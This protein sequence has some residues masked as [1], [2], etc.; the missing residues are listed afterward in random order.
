MLCFSI[1]AARQRIP[2]IDSSYNKGG[3]NADSLRLRNS[4]PVRVTLKGTRMTFLKSHA[5]LTPPLPARARRL[6][7]VLAVCLVIAVSGSSQEPA[8]AN[9]AQTPDPAPAQIP[10]AAPD[11]T[12]AQT[13]DPTPAQPPVQADPGAQPAQPDAAQPAPN[14]AVPPAAAQDTPAQPAAQS[15]DTP[16]A[17]DQA[18]ATPGQK[19]AGEATGEITEDELKNMLVGKPL[20][21]RNGY[22]FDSLSYNEL[23]MLIGKSPHASYTLSAVQ[24]EKVHLTK[25]KLELEGARYGLHFLGSLASEDPTAGIDRV[26]ITPKKKKLRISI[27]REIVIKPKKAKPE[28]PIKGKSETKPADGQV[29]QSKDSIA[30]ATATLTP[31]MPE[32]APGA[33]NGATPDASAPANAP[34]TEPAKT[35][36]STTAGQAAAPAESEAQDADQGK[37]EIAAAPKEE[38]PADPN[39]VTFTLS[40]A[41]AA[42]IL[43][44]AIGNVFAIGLDDKLMAAMPDFWKLYYQAAKA[45][46]DYRPAD[47]AVLRQN[48]VDEKA[49]ITS[50][51]EPAS[52]QYAQDNGVAGMS[53]YHVVIGPDG[54]PGEIAVA[55]PI[56]FGLDEN[57]VTAIQGAKFT[58]ATKDGKSVPVLLDLVVQFRIYSKRTSIIRIP[59]QEDNPA[60]PV[61]PGP[62]TAHEMAMRK[63]E[64]PQQT[65]SSN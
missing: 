27:D 2:W 63:R 50:Q 47:P 8:Q 23:G 32:V 39:S 9:P 22:L 5:I 52:N 64:S 7:A 54:T 31:Q 4:I 38:R 44:K 61:L 20:F 59:G 40:P 25:H 35:D 17:T 24:I 30:K 12:P 18:G 16:A 21:L 56:G 15:A 11:S 14:E 57:A 1:R 43:K 48:T 55:R 10:A 65:T 53:L 29:V 6:A 28:K 62:Y 26:R 36:A 3:R 42:K 41:H 45:G 51:F 58:P 19:S 46:T 13:P 37:A 60:A 33:S 49:K 34:G